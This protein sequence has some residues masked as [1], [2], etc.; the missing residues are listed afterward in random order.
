MTATIEARQ[1]WLAARAAA[2]FVRRCHGDLH[3]GNLCLWEGAPVAFDALEF[4]E[5]M[6][7]IDV[8]YD[9]GFLLMDLDRRVGRAAANRV[10]NRYVARTGDA[11]ATGGLPMFLSQRAMVRA[12][13]LA[14]TGGRDE[15]YK[16]LRAAEDYV[17]PRPPFVLAIGGLQGTGKST[18]ARRVAP[19]L[20]LPRGR[21]SCAAM[22]CASA[23]T[24]CRRRPG[25][26]RT[27]IPRPP[28]RR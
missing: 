27:P 20:V 14:A 13:V 28:T 22:N 3:L 24:A 12:H 21:L 2:G 1:A 8:G 16:Y 5:A 11:Q 10:M 19:D 9:L 18:V 17:L 26:H 7:T 23:C 15:A 25:C 4:D 6:A